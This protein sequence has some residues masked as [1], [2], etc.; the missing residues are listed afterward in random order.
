MV[1]PIR[2]AFVLALLA[3]FPAF[4]RADALQA[5]IAKAVWDHF[6]GAARR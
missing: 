1:M 4:A 2:A 5:E 3:V 6:S